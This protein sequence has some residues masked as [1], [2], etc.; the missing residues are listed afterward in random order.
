[1][2]MHLHRSCAC[3]SRAA[4]TLHASV[5]SGD[6]GGANMWI[7][8]VRGGGTVWRL[9]QCRP[10][11]Q[12][13]TWLAC[14]H[15][16]GCHAGQSLL[17]VG[18]ASTCA[19]VTILNCDNGIF[20]NWIDHSTIDGTVAWG[21]RRTLHRSCHAGHVHSV[22][23]AW[24]HQPDYGL[25]PAPGIPCLGV[26]LA[27]EPLRLPLPCRRGYR[28][29]GA[30]LGSRRLAERRERAPP[31]LLDRV[32]GQPHH[33][34]SCRNTCMHRHREQRSWQEVLFWAGCA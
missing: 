25:Q 8:Q 13:R 26:C 18:P 10:G 5:S 32:A 4:P 27:A 21:A 12:Q 33:Q 15:F 6:A 24:P 17:P 29:D 14:L 7:R 11:V 22:L 1:M 23:R 34:A 20:L 3:A 31:H 30:A 16:V 2:C 9:Q 28:R 19:Q